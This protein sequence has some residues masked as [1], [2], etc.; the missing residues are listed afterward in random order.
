MLVPPPVLLLALAVLCVVV[1]LA[2]L[3]GFSWSVLGAVAGG[4]VVA[5]S[6]ALL[7]SSSRAFAHAGTPV[8]PTSPAVAVVAQGPYRFSRNP[9][10][11]GMVGLLL[12]FSLL[13]DSWLFAVAA[14]V[15][16]VVVNFGVILPEERY[17]E[18]LHGDAYR[19]FKSR[20]RRWL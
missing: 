13:G 1:Q 8:R 2:V 20:V 18:A 5:A 19:Q 3:N 14:I 7:R 6:V 11:L 4:L 9:M 12:G 17:M 15:F 10:Y 16:A